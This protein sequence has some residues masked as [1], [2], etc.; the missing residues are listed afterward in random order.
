MLVCTPTPGKEVFA[1]EQLFIA[2]YRDAASGFP[3]PHH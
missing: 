3:A 2:S 1:L